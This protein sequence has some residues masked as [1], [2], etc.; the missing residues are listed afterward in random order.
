MYD[1]K[2]STTTTGR[3]RWSSHYDSICSLLKLYKPTFLVLK[4][5]A[6][7]RGFGTTPAGRAKAAGAV[8]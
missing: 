1:T 7:A 3:A 5:I 2:R 6:T 8:K 4:D